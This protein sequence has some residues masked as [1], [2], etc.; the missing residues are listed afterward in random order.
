MGVTMPAYLL[1]TNILIDLAGARRSRAFFQS[2]LQQSDTRI[3]TSILC[4]AEYLAGASAAEERFLRQW[5]ASGELQIVYLDELLDAERAAQLRK[6]YGLALPDALI[7]AGAIRV[8]GRLLTHD[9]L[10][11]QKARKEVAVSDPLDT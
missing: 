5:L 11:L 4:V 3:L 8:E 1:D 10:L 2:A 6:R 9:A 7:V